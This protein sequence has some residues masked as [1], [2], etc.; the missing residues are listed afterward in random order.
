MGGIRSWWENDR[1]VTQR[2]FNNALHES[3]AAP[4][5]AEPWICEKILDL[6]LKSPSMF[7]IIPLADWLS[8]DGNIR[9]KNPAEEQINE[10][11]NPKHYWRY[12]MHLTVEELL[13][14]KEFNIRLMNAIK[15]S[16]R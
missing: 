4:Y 12:R 16:S 3:G 1:E 10:P 9:R 14:Q 2:F 8:A 11:A 13:S 15:S 6:Q 5:F 7:C